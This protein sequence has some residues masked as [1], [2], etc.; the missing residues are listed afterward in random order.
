RAED[1]SH[2]YYLYTS[3]SSNEVQIRKMNGS[4]NE[5]LASGAPV[6]GG[7]QGNWH[8]YRVQVESEWIRVW[9]DGE[10]RYEITDAGASSD[11]YFAGGVGLRVNRATLEVDHLSVYDCYGTTGGTTVDVAEAAAAPLGGV[12]AYP[13]PFNP[14]TT[15]R[16]ELA[17]ASHAQVWILDATGR[18]VR[19]LFEGELPSGRHE[20]VWN[21][22]DNGSRRAASGVYYLRVRAAQRTETRSIVLLQ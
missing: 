12:S 11:P 6:C 18:M 8:T 5:I 10:R 1:A 16:F 15:A 13:N 4:T 22:L 9:V 17:R 20:I 7:V 2:Y 21:G 19:R 14:R 3:N